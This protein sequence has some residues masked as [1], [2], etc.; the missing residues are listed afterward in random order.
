MPAKKKIDGA[1]LIKMVADGSHQKEIMKAF[2]FNTAAQFKTHYLDAL[3]KAG[4]APEIKSGRGIAKARS[5]KEVLVSKR[6]SVVVPK[7][8]IEEMGFAEGEK[9]IVRKTK[10]GISLKAIG[11]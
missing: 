4:K 8:M 3:M 11:K 2:K 10:S 6:G 5:S 9:F 1:K 7:A